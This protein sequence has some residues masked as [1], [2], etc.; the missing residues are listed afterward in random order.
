MQN[1]SVTLYIKYPLKVYQKFNFLEKSMCPVKANLSKDLLWKNTKSITKTI[2]SNNSIKN[3][4]KQKTK[5]TGIEKYFSPFNDQFPS[6]IETR[7]FIYKSKKLTGF[8][9]RGTLVV[10]GLS[11]QFEHVNVSYSI[12][13]H[14]YWNVV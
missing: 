6:H 13:G 4:K 10:I 3:T 2:K 8:Y 14:Q 9:M 1:T 12:A 7:K 5:H 11:R